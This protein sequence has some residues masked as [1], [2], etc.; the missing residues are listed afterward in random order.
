VTQQIGAVAA[1]AVVSLLLYRQA[2]RTDTVIRLSCIVMAIGWGFCCVASRR[3]LGGSFARVSR[4]GGFLYLGLRNMSTFF[5]TLTATI[6]SDTVLASSILLLIGHFYLHDYSFTTGSTEKIRGTLSMSCAV[7]AS[8]L[9]SSRM[10]DSQHV[11][12]QLIFCFE[13]FLLFPYIRHYVRRKSI[14]MHC[15]L[16]GTMAIGPIYSLI[17]DLHAP[18]AAGCLLLTYGFITFICPLAFLHVQRYKLVVEGPWDD[19]ILPEEQDNLC[20]G[21]GIHKKK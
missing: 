7:G 3:I 13:L 5:A 20:L 17:F 1:A 2:I 14:L 15:I 9:V 11:F 12:A 19:A 18:Y 10:K 16:T 4:Q 21:P 6:S 8:V